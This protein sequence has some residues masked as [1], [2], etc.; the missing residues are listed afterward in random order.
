MIIAFPIFVPLNSPW[1]AVYIFSIPSV[2]VSLYFILPWKV[3]HSI[4]IYLLMA[5]EIKGKTKYEQKIL[6][7]TY[8]W[9]VIN[10]NNV[11]QNATVS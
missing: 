11:W 9:W 2:T 4:Y 6:N 5:F 8:A 3:S 10:V 1:N 7:K